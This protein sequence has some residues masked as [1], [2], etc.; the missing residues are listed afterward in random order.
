MAAAAREGEFSE[1][2]LE[3]AAILAD[4]PS[5]VRASNRRRRQQEKQQRRQQARPEIPSWGRRR[6]RRAPAEAAAA[7][8]AEKPVAADDDRSEGVASPD[9]PL[10]FPEDDEHAEAAAAAATEDEAKATAQ[11]KW[12]QEQRGV[13]ASLSHENAHL[14]KQIEDFRARLHT[15]RSTNDSLKQIQQSKHKK[16]HRPEEEDEGRRWRL[17]Q[18]RA[19]DRPA[20]DLNEP[21]EADA[22]DGR[23]PQIAAPAAQWVHRGHHH[24]QNQQQQLMQMQHKA[25]RRR[26]Q[27]IRR[28][29]AAAG[30][31]RR[32]G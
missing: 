26:R 32:Q 2:E 22:E 19:A 7:P 31:T 16:R 25:A 4:L 20:L 30:R 1:R 28:A 27:E 21:A 10:A 24:Q 8:P 29:K 17:P 15:S 13:V 5:I 11:D 14:L 12:A 23:Q 3:V 18:A 6:P 9:T